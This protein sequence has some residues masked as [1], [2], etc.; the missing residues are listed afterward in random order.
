MLEVHF[1]YNDL[2][3]DHKK[4]F[5]GKF[6]KELVFHA[7]ELFENDYIIDL[8]FKKMN[9][10]NLLIAYKERLMLRYKLKNYKILLIQCQ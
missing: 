9:Q 1:S 5:K 3:L 10:K 6:G 7:P 8:T 2:G 4:Y